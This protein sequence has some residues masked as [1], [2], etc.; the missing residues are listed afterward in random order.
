MEE[1]EEEEEDGRGYLVSRIIK[2]GDPL[3]FVYVVEGP[4]ERGGV[5]RK[6]RRKERR[7]GKKIMKNSETGMEGEGDTMENRL[8]WRGRRRGG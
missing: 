2:A 8:E 5:W 3:G 6:E 4:G 7:K 1:E